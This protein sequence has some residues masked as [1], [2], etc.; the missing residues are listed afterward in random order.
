M[1]RIGWALALLC[2][3]QCNRALRDAMERAEAAHARGDHFG[4]AVALRDAC[5]AAPGE[6]EI[7]RAAKESADEIISRQLQTASGPCETEPNACLAALEVLSPFAGAEDPRLTGYFDRAGAMLDERCERAP[8]QTLEDAVFRVRCVEAYRARVPT[9]GYAALIGKV[10]QQSG[11]FV[12]QAAQQRAASPGVA[13]VH[14]ALAGCLGGQAAYAPRVQAYRAAFEAAHGVRLAVTGQSSWRPGELCV[15]LQRGLGTLLRCDGRG[16]EALQVQVDTWVD[17]MTDSALREVRQVDVLDRR[18]RFEN[19][20]YRHAQGKARR[21]QGQFDEAAKRARLAR[22]DCETAQGV[23]SRAGSCTNCRSRTE[24]DLECNRRN[25]AEDLEKRSRKELVAAQDALSRTPAFLE[26]DVYRAVSYRY[27]QHHFRVPWHVRVSVEGGAP[28]ERAGV[29]TFDSTESDGVPAANIAA[30]AYSEP[31][32]QQ[33]REGLEQAA[34]EL[35][36][37]SVA[38][39]LDRRAQA[40]LATCPA[41]TEPSDCQVEAQLLARQDPA[42]QFAADVGARLDLRTGQPWPKAACAP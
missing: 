10:R 13:W 3:C 38:Q 29:L 17:P 34:Y 24:M 42:A 9:Q 40:R 23:L 11:A 4:E 22:A 8:L 6:Q 32:Q 7:C 27:V 20:D 5:Q 28:F 19:P 37:A 36:A 30:I 16:T 18:E 12:D 35:A 39:E 2:L 25:A 14:E 21:A 26:R 31:T 15:A 1:T 41:P 33:R